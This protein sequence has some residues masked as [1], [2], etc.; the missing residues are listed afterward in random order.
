MAA[1]CGGCI[2]SVVAVLAE[3]WRQRGSGAAMVGS[4]V[5]ALAM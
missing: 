4:A 1:K 5:V 3:R 2:G